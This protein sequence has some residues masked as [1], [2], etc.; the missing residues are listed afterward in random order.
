MLEPHS[1]CEG[2]AIGVVVTNLVAL[3]FGFGIRRSASKNDV[4]TATKGRIVAQLL[5]TCGLACT[6]IM[7]LST[8]SAYGIA[9]LT[10]YTGARA[11]ALIVEFIVSDCSDSSQ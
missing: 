6:V 3:I 8:E 9:L 4:R 1:V 11:I 10:G 7:V 2:F 5:L